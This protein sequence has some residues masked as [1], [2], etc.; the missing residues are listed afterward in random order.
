LVESEPENR[1]DILPLLVATDGMLAKLGYD[2]RRFRP[3]LVVA[4]IAGLTER[5]WEGGALRTGETVI[6]I[7]D[8]RP[9]C[10]M[11]TYDPD[12]LKQDLNVLRR[13]QKEFAGPLGLNCY[14]AAPE[15]A[16]VGD[17]VE[18]G[19]CLD[20]GGHGLYLQIIHRG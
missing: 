2:R 13:V 16:R 7:E 19:R 3:N 17:S 5:Q 18:F 15:H 1:F 8:L 6:G 4:G 20:R 10:I 9:R 12:T 11:D 14:V